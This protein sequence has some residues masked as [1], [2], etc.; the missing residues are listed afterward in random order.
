MADVSE[1][2]RSGTRQQAALRRRG[3]V[4]VGQ[5]QYVRV[6]VS[7]LS[8]RRNGRAAVSKESS[9]AKFPKDRSRQSDGATP[10]CQPGYAPATGFD[11][12]LARGVF[13]IAQLSAAIAV[14]DEADNWCTADN[15]IIAAR[16]VCGD[17]LAQ[18]TL[19]EVPAWQLD[20]AGD[21]PRTE[22]ET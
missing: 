21:L 17:A 22:E 19:D 6:Q 20:A 18:A 14:H 2:W 3:S 1:V 4:V 9:A 10:V 15:V 8:G 13:Y 5:W 16:A 7:R 12:L 11:E